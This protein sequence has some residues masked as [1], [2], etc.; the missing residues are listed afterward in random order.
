MAGFDNGT[1]QSGLFAQAKQFGSVLRGF[2]PPA[3]TAGVLGDLYID[4]QTWLLYAKTE[5]QS[6]DPWGNWL[7]QVPAAYQSSLKWFSASQPDNSI[8]IAG[9]YCL[10]WGGLNNYGIQPSIYGPKAGNSW[11]EGGDGPITPLDPAYAGYALP[12]GLSDE[13]TPAAYSNSSQLIASGLADEYIL[14]L[15][16]PQIVNSPVYE[17][18]L[19]S[20]P[21]NVPVVVNPSY[22]ATDTHPV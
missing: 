2:G 3:P 17:L 15:P 7:F 10:L 9:D 8:G 6:T 14:A 1:A 21:V 22:A 18:G 4:V 11:P 20:F 12:V 5:Q 19:S 16:V 13:G